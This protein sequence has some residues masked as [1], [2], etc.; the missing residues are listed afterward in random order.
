M[1]NYL[2]FFVI[3]ECIISTICNIISAITSNIL[4]GLTCSLYIRV[5]ELYIGHVLILLVNDK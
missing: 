5:E 4:Q 2:H 1:G 3:N